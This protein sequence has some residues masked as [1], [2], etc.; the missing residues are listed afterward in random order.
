MSLSVPEQ[1]VARRLSTI[2]CVHLSELGVY[3]HRLYIYVYLSR[4][5]PQRAVVRRLAKFR[6]VCSCCLE[7]IHAQAL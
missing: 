6:Y 3:S 7:F 4:R 2:R 1:V 5:M